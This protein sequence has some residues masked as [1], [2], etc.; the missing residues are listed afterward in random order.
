[1][2]ETGVREYAAAPGNQG[3]W[4]LRRDLGDRCKFVMFTL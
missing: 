1:M 2:N 4:M 3:V